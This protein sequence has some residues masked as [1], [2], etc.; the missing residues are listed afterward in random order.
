MASASPAVY[1]LLVRE[2]HLDTFGHMNNAMYLSILEEARWQLIT[3]RGYSLNEIKKRG[4]GPVILEVNLKFVKELFLR[5]EIQIHTSLMDYPGKVGHLKQQIFN[6]KSELA[7]EA[8][9]TVALFDL[10]ERKIIE[11]TP[12]WRKAVGLD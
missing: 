3:E 4:Q 5:E 11:P 12:E 9:F 2:F 6:S 8:V 1:K 10:K 7:A